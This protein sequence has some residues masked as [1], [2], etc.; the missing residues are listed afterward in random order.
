M[1]GIGFVLERLLVQGG[2]K[3][4]L[5]VAMSGTALIAGPWLLSA[6]SIF[7]AVSLVPQ[8]VAAPFQQTLVYLFAGSLLLFGGFH[9]TYTRKVADLHFYGM[10]RAQRRLLLKSLMKVAA[11][12]LLLGFGLAWFAAAEEPTIAALRE[13]TVS[14][15]YLLQGV[16][17]AVMMMAVNV[18]FLEMIHATQIERFVLVP[19]GYVFG[20]VAIIA[21]ARPLTE[22]L[23]LL[24]MYAA[25]TV[26]FI[27]VDIF[28]FFVS[29]SPK[30]KS[31][32]PSASDEETT[33]A[34][35]TSPPAGG[36]RREVLEL[37]VA[38]SALYI[39]LWMDKLYYWIVLGS[40]VAGTGL[41]GYPDY[42]VAIFWGQ[43]TIIPGLIYYLVAGETDFF[44]E[45]R[46]TVRAVMNR[47]YAGVQLQKI[48]LIKVHKYHLSRQTL[49]QFAFV[50]ALLPLT[51]HL[52]ALIYGDT[53]G[54]TT[55]LM[56]LI[57]SALYLTHYTLFISL[58]YFKR[59]RE[60]AGST[61][62]A[63]LV[64]LL[65]LIIPDRPELWLGLPFALGSLA[66]MGVSSLFFLKS[67]HLLDRQL[68]TRR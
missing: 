1:A 53:D 55:I 39:L 36:S 48:Q 59:Y 66:G 37:W 51:P 50:A 38:G 12:S 2:V 67:A 23:G 61:A 49:L 57:G 25:F 54:T 34:E 21:L 16:V 47:P 7:L 31:S 11:A 68:L 58:L 29:L 18:S 35:Q 19:L 14:R 46:R 32:R 6:A 33:P 27:L 63:I 28:L 45:L 40:P 3:N 13:G 30:R 10:K 52:A 8:Q 9:L 5:L 62:A 4:I 15:R 60:A 42:D 65:L 20:G 43:I 56:V 26:G 41:S 24:G 22:S 64:T 44:R 17:I